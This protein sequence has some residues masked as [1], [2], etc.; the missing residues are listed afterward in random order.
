MIA[1]RHLSTRG[2]PALLV[3]LVAAAFGS[4]P[5]AAQDQPV[6]LVIA[7]DMVLGGKNIPEDQRAS[8]ACVMTSRFPR[9]GE[10]VWRSRVFDPA[11]GDPLDGDALAKVEVML[12]DGQTFEMEY[13]A[14]PPAP[15]PP[16]D[17]YWTV[18]WVVPKDYPTGTLSYTIVATDTQGR[19][20]EFKPFDIPPSLPTIT[21]EVLADIAEEEEEEEEEA[22]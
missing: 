4:S 5:V 20:G 11:T 15:N 9:N 6:K 21:E 18:A 16:R 12:S 10:L 19:S 1:Y 14:H 7:A 17:Y 8:R 2:R 13:G 3:G 22:A